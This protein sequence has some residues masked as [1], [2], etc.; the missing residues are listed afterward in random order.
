MALPGLRPHVRAGRG[1]I[2]IRIAEPII[3]AEEEAAV[4]DVLRSGRL[5][6]GERVAAFEQAVARTIGVRH[7]VAV[8]NGTAAL[9][10]ALQAHGIGA[11]D[12]VIVPAFTFGAS[13][14]SVL[15][16][17][18]RPVLVDIRP[19]D[20]NIDPERP[21]AAVTPKTRAVVVVH[22]YGHPCDMTAIDAVARQHGLVVIEDACQALGAAWQGRAAGSFGTG[23]LS[24]YATKSITTGEGG[25]VVTDDG[26][27]ADRARLL[28]NQ[29]EG[30]RY[31]TDV[32]GYNFRM[33]ELAAALGLAQLPK[34]DGWIERRRANAAWLSEHL[35]GVATPIERPGAQ[36]TYQQYTVRVPNGRRD[37]LQR[38]LR[39]RD[40]ES[41][42]YYPL[43]LHQ[44]PLYKEVGIGGSFPVAESAAGEVLSLPVHAA[45]SQD[46]LERIAAAVNETMAAVGARGG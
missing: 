24:F 14:N 7:A 6:Q 44:Q 37:A 39:E 12:E 35:E 30:E 28:R 18:A 17:G 36:H 10:V 34:L 19:E 8:S 26:G 20:Y 42:V 1:A 22:L 38:A 5:V 40:I 33:T 32:L 4:L 41:V 27:L 45:L 16:A 13:G 15:L 9:V 31:R 43:A 2:V 25:M 3:G 11:G 46:D 23:C 29:G 21:A